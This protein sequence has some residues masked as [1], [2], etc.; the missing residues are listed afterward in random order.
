MNKRPNLYDFV[1][2]TLQQICL[3]YMMN[4]DDR[5]LFAGEIIRGYWLAK[6]NLYTDRNGRKSEWKQLSRWLVIA[7]VSYG[8]NGTEEK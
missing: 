8:K 5:A 7:S 2:T 1:P 6:M 4:K 3:K